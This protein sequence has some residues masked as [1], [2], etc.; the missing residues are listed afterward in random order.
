MITINLRDPKVVSNLKA[1]EAL[2]QTNMY[3]ELELQE[4]Y[5]EQIKQ[6]NERRKNNG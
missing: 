6:D 5:D 1:I 2:K 3:S 4:M